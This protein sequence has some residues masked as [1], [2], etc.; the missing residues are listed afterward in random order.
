MRLVVAAL[1]VG[2]VVAGIGD[3]WWSSPSAEP[4]V[5][6]FLLDWQQESYATAATLTTGQPAVVTTALRDAYRQLD[7]ASF[8]LSMGPIS[9]HGKTATASFFANVDLGQNGAPWIYQGHF[10][11]H[12]TPV[13]LEDRLESQRDQPGLA[14]RAPSG[15]VVLHP[16]PG[17]R[18]STPK[19]ARCKLSAP[20]SWPGSGRTG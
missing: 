15:D 17:S 1:L 9:Q 4:V 18:C 3:G 2:F 14:A 6:H 5:Q 8:F 10:P 19:G 16:C 12:L 11:L 7:A 20:R 13:R